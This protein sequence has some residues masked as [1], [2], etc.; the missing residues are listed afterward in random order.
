MIYIAADKHGYKAKQFVEAYLASR[1]IS[2]KNLGVQTENQEEKLE[3]LIPEV[4]RRVQVDSNDQGILICGTGVGM[5]VGANKFKNIR[6]CLVTDEKI[7]GWARI[8]DN[9]NILCLVGWDAKEKDIYGILDNWF[10]SK[11]DEDP[12]RKLMLE[13]FERWR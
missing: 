9:C 5:A 8:Y 1:K 4:V 13:K 6:A 10:K 7:A 3:K 2:F 11:F 12:K